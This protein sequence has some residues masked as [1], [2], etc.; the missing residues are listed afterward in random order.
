MSRPP[1]VGGFGPCV[2]AALLA[3]PAG[4]DDKPGVTLDTLAALR[5]AGRPALADGTTA[6]VRE[7]RVGGRF[8]WDA[9]STA[10]ADGGTVVAPDGAGPGRWV[11]VFAG[12]LDAGWFG[13]APG[14]TAEGNSKAFAAATAALNRAGGGTLVVPP[15]EYRVG[16]QV[17]G[18]TAATGRPPDILRVEGCAKPVVLS[19]AGVTLK[20]A[21][22]LRY[23]SFHPQTGKRFDPPKLPFNDPAYCQN[24]YVMV[25][26]RH[27]S[28]PVRVEGF[29][30]DGN[31][32]R[33]ELG[34]QYNDTGR[35]CLAVGIFLEGN[36]GGVDVTGVR[37]RDHGLDG[38]MAAHYK[39]TPA[40]PRYPVRLTDVACEGN[41]RQGLSWVG[42]TEL[43]ATRCRFA[44]TGRG[45][46]ASAPAAGVDV[47]AEDSVCRNGRFVECEFVDNAGCGL[48][49]DSGDVAD[50][51]LERC[52]FVGTTTWSAWPRKPGVVFDGCRFVG[53]VVNAFG[54]PDPARAT[55]FRKCRFTAD[56]KLSPTGAVFGEQ[57]ANF[58]GGGRNVLL[59]DCD[60]EAVDPGAGLPW[61]PAD[62]RYHDCRFRQA[63]TAPSHPRGV[64]T[65][66]C[67]PDRL[68][69]AGG[70]VRVAVRGPADGQRQA[71]A[72]TG[73]MPPP[74][75]VPHERRRTPPRP[76]RD[77]PPRARAVRAG[78]P[79]GLAAGRRRQVCVRG[80]RHRR[81]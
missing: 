21:D 55:Q 28:G 11:R 45:A 4:A 15:G 73:R 24:A 80:R 9:A 79:P 42:G 77:R 35:Q 34:G 56:R 71:G 26:V 70:P 78:R 37:A 18:Q 25:Y 50:L 41:G 47:E 49:A 6:T 69:R 54:D 23:G 68:G 30:L 44:R 2:L 7:A 46:F 53:A 19:G 43:V 57:V 61:S 33:Y 32:G 66:T 58:G 63:G 39:L 1:S 64:F 3:A 62:V 27:C 8:R 81:L 40:S 60:F 16:Y 38:V 20:A 67:Q 13:A 59:S 74:P 75:E 17:P 31:L 48:V 12:P 51:R 65:G 76:G 36:T 10:A 22:G 14:A 52:L 29:E 5:A 72:V